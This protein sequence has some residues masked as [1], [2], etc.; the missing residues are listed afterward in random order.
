MNTC[1][2]LTK[3]KIGPIGFASLQACLAI[4]KK[5]NYICTVFD[6]EQA[7]YRAPFLTIGNE[8]LNTIG[9]TT[10]YRTIFL[11]LLSEA[12]R[13]LASCIECLKNEEGI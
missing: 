5:K 8:K 10:E 6:E 2:R 13:Q 11:S 1:H 12:A 4:E 9:A 3:V 7:W